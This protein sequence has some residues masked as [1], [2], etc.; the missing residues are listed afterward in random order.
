MYKIDLHTHS[1][2]SSDGGLGLEAYRSK[3]D[4]KKLDYIAITDHDSIAFALE[5]YKELGDRI[6][7]GEEIS[8]QDGEIIGLFLTSAVASNMSA[9]KTVKAI[10]QQGGLV[11]VPHPFETLRKGVTEATLNIIK[12][13]V[14]I[15]EAH[16]GRTFQ[17]KLAKKSLA[18]A[19]ENNKAYAASSDAHGR[20][21]WGKTYSTVNDKLSKNN[22][23]TLLN[24]AELSR[25][26]IGALGRLHPSINRIKKRLRDA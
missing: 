25:G 17:P 18:W 5:A 8:T 6:I 10:K 20:L 11:Y 14:D 3:L 13:E 15:I 21:G 19:Q 16:N 7:V 22:L 24:E 12:K 9:E 23:V 4:T 1:I 26:K 2:D